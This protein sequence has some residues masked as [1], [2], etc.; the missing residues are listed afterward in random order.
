[1]TGSGYR[2]SIRLVAPTPGRVVADLEDDFHHFT[3]TLGH[4]GERVTAVE[5]GAH[6]YPWTTCPGAVVPL[7][8]VAG[9]TLSLDAN[10]LTAT[11]D[12]RRNCTHL[13]DLASL[14]VA[15]AA[16]GTSARR[17]EISV[18][19]RDQGRTVATL[20]RDGEPCLRWE[21]Q[22]TRV[23]GPA[24]YADVPLRGG[25]LAW[26]S[27][28]LDTEEAE[29]AVVLRRACDISMGRMM[30]LDAIER[31]DELAEIMTGTCHTFQ[32]GIMETSLRV[33]GSTRRA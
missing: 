16:R 19:D 8:E 24:P 26:A 6:R 32:P 2:R 12:P 23:V 18:A 1:L 27:A 5:G 21:V 29:A 33:K 11:V 4:D 17:Y 30:D 13:F 28:N 14:A 10:A 7:R 22:G 9:A 15:H 25:F 3:V 20:D 31:A